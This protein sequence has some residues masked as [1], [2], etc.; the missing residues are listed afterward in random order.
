MEKGIIPAERSREL[1]MSDNVTDPEPKGSEPVF[2]IRIPT[3]V[4]DP[5]PQESG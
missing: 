2:R 3:I 5:E 1:T 4:S